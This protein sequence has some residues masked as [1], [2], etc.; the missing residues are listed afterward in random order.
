MA[1]ITKDPMLVPEYSAALGQAMASETETFGSYVTVAGDGRF[2]TLMRAAYSFVNADLA[3]LYGVSGVMG[4]ELRKVDLDP[5]FRSGLLTQLAF[6]TQTAN[7]TLWTSPTH[8]GLYVAKKFLCS[9]PPAPPPGTTL[10]VPPEASPAQTARQRLTDTTSAAACTACHNLFDPVG[11]AFERF[12]TLGR[13]RSS[14]NGLPIDTSG[15]VRGLSSGNVDFADVIELGAVLEAAP[16][17]H[18]CMATQW[19]TYALGR[20]LVDDDQSSVTTIH[21]LFE[22]SGLD[23]RTGFAAALSSASFLGAHGGPP[24]LSGTGQSCNDDPRISSLHGTCTAG[25]KC[26]CGDAYQLNPATGRCL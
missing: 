20:T 19:L 9:A 13:V 17:V 16:E 3:A 22:G 25:G 8:R 2:S 6:L 15:T 5:A 18:R 12:D 7:Q 14:D 1:S 10:T 23:L 4:T 26:V 24:C 11:F 21:Q